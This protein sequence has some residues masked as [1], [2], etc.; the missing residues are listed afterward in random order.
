MHEYVYADKILQTVLDQSRRGKKPRAVEVKVGELLGL[1]RESLNSAYAVL[2][3]GTKAEGSSLRVEIAR[4]V[5]SCSSCSFEGHI[6]PKG[7]H[8][9]DPV[10]ACPECGAPLKVKS[11]LE[12]ELKGITWEGGPDE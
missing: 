1:T 3:K 8:H 2:S 7:H 5:V 9:V 11:G 4:G 12:V 6:A 10:F